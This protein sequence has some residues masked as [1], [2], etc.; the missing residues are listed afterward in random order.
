MITTLCRT[1]AT[2]LAVFLDH[3]IVPRRVYAF[4]DLSNELHDDTDVRRDTKVAV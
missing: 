2:P 1:L 4:A 3:V